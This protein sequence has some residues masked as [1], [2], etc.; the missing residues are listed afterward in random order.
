[1]PQ[2]L[3]W[4]GKSR[5]GFVPTI[6]GSVPVLLANPRRKGATIVNDSAANVIYLAKGDHAIVNTGIRLNAAGGSYEINGQ[7]LWLGPISAAC[8]A[9]AANITWTE[10][11]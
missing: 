7:N 11:E 2:D 1:M 6:I 9:A 4:Q 3:N 8:A 10:D 5:A